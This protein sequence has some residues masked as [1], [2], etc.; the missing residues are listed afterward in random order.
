[1]NFYIPARYYLKLSR[2][3]E[4]AGFGSDNSFLFPYISAYLYLMSQRKLFLSFK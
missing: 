3:F 2:D 4:N 1:M